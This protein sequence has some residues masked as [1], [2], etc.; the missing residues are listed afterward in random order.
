ML[1]P[2]PVPLVENSELATLVRSVPQ[3]SLMP[4]PWI[5][6]S[7]WP[8]C[9]VTAPLELLPAE[10]P[11]P[12]PAPPTPVAEQP[13]PVPLPAAQA[14]PVVVRPPAPEPPDPLPVEPPLLPVVVPP[15]PVL[16]PPLPVL[17]PLVPPVAFVDPPEPVLVDPPEPVFCPG[18]LLELQPHNSALARMTLRNFLLPTSASDDAFKCLRRSD[19]SFLGARVRE[20]MRAPRWDEIP[21][22]SHPDR[23]GAYAQPESISI[24]L[25][26]IRIG[27]RNGEMR[28]GSQRQT[29]Q[30]ADVQ[31]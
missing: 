5:V 4:N 28:S 12:A 17:P 30:L 24:G 19:L 8:S 13:T 9:T 23:A 3:L 29:N 18:P 11:L 14:L 10:P 20:R 7:V 25:P 15:L 16:V 22:N 1:S 21:G 31:G 6:C 27:R 26:L 2:S